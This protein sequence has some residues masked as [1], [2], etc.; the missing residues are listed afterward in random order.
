MATSGEHRAQADAKLAVLRQHRD[1]IRTLAEQY[2][3]SNIRVFSQGADE[4]SG[5]NQYDIHLLVDLEP[6]RSLFDTI[7]CALD[8]EDKF[9]VRVE[10]LTLADLQQNQRAAAEAAASEL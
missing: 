6:D 5:S 8:I 9:G 1:E 7:G 10:I 3:I 2:G 4:I